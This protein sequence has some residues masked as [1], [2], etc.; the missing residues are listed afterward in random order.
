MQP[1]GIGEEHDLNDSV[2]LALQY[3]LDNGPEFL[4]LCHVFS[5]T[6]SVAIGI[7]LEL[8]VQ[9]ELSFLRGKQQNPGK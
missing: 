1:C 6:H 4:Y 2:R 9:E 5:I 7:F 3:L 8:K